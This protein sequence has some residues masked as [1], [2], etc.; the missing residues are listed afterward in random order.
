MLHKKGVLGLCCFA[1]VYFVLIMFECFAQCVQFK[2]KG[3]PIVLIK[4]EPKLNQEM[5]LREVG[6]L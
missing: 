3:H 4:G 6:Q 2:K 5:G 1:T